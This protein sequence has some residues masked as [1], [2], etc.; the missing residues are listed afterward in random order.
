[1]AFRFFR[2]MKIAPGVS[3]NFSKSGVS[4]SFG[5]RG[6]RGT[7]GRQGGADLSAHPLPLIIVALLEADEGV[8]DLVQNGVA[9]LGFVV[10]AGEVAGE[11]EDL[12]AGLSAPCVALLADANGPELAFAT[13]PSKLPAV[14]EEAMLFHQFTSELFGS[15][16]FHDSGRMSNVRVSS[17][18][19]GRRQGTPRR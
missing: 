13:T 18:W 11:R 16:K 5:V 10:E 1:M 7:V 3:L 4:P 2:R 15:I 8:S 6:A 12:H 17:E 19:P 14:L 9:D